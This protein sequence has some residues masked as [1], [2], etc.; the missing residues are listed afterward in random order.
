MSFQW[1][2]STDKLFRRCQRQFFFRQIAAHASASEDWRREAFILRQVK[3]LELWRGALIHEGIEHF[4]IPALRSG[5]TLPWDEII[6]RTVQRGRDQ[7]SFSERRRYREPG[8]VKGRC[9]DFCALAP[10]EAGEAVSSEDF[11]TVCVAIRTAFE[12]LSSLTQLWERFGEQH[13][14]EAEVPL[15]VK[16]QDVSIKVQIDVLLERSPHQLTIVDWKS[17]DVGGDTDA[18]LQTA[19]Y[20]WVVWRSKQYRVRCPEDIELLEC[21]VQHGTLIE[22]ECS[23]EVFDELEDYIYRSVQRIFSLCQSKK[24]AETRLEDFAFTDNPNNCEHCTVRPLCVT[25]LSGSSTPSLTLESLAPPHH[26]KQVTL[27]LI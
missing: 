4:L 6:A 8:I 22:H 14:W 17:Y 23:R 27:R 13:Y 2:F 9:P 11:E 15:C 20:A 21:Q 25:M 5:G 7:L 1:S 10:H 19:L 26:Q 3:T 12:R 16:R 18:R 24:L